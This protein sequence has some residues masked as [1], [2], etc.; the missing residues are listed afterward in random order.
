MKVEWKVDKREFHLVGNLAAWKAA[1]SA[2]PM[3]DSMVAQ[4]AACS[5][6]C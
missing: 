4:L 3:A 2:F 6:D 1:H 5:V